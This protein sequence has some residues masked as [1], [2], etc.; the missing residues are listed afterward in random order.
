MHRLLFLLALL[1]VSARA[2][3]SDGNI[4]DSLPEYHAQDASAAVVTEQNLLASERFWPYQVALEESWQPAGRGQPLPPDAPGVLIRVDGSGLARIDFGRDGL[5]EVPVGRT[6]LVQRANR[7][8]RGELEKIAPNFLLAI[9][10]RLIDSGSDSLRPFPVGAAVEQQAFLCVFADPDAEGFGALAS[11]LIPLRERRGLLIILFP[12]GAR[13]DA[14]VRER[15]RS[16]KW[17]VPFVY[18]HLSESYTRTLLADAT[19]PPAVLLQTRDGRVLFQG[20]WR[21]DAV[22]DLKSA[23]AEAFGDQPTPSHY[24]DRGPKP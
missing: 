22:P 14:R 18:D 24:A 2:D 5:Y 15:L 3:F 13:A 1:A 16:L 21:A 7:I 10:P 23:I 9:A 17:S 4:V 12:Q 20:G 19:P 6:D 11:G 8:R